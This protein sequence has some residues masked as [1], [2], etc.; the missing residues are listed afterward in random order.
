MRLAF[1]SESDRKMLFKFCLTKQH[2]DCLFSRRFAKLIHGPRCIFIVTFISASYRW[3]WTV[4]PEDTRTGTRA[5][6]KNRYTRLLGC[7]LN[8]PIDSTRFLHYYALSLLPGRI[9]RITKSHTLAS[10]SDLMVF[11][12][13]PLAPEDRKQFYSIGEICY[14]NLCRSPYW[15]W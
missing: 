1:F 5:R 13:L 12:E 7:F 14:Q 9:H 10:K 4:S 2:I 15:S 11:T 3:T 8:A 6:T